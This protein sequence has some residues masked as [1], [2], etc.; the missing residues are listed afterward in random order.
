MNRLQA[1]I[2]ATLYILIFILITCVMFPVIEIS[3][4][5]LH[6]FKAKPYHH[7]QILQVSAASPAPMIYTLQCPNASYFFK[8]VISIKTQQF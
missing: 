8:R 3:I 5:G 6:V 4:P 2:S 1:L 7:M